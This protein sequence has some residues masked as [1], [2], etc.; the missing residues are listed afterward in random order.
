MK[1]QTGFT[2]VYPDR[3]IPVAMLAIRQREDPNR[4]F[5]NTVEMCREIAVDETLWGIATWEDIDPRIVRFSV[6]VSGLTNA[7]RWKDLA[8][9]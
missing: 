6:Y 4:K 3:V 1:E 8:G 2:K 5:L 7:Y 9:E